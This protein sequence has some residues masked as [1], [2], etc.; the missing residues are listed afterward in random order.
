MAVCN[1]LKANLTDTSSTRRVL[2]AQLSVA[3]QP[4]EEQA[5]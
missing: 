1:R 4:V 3:V 2:D 5:A